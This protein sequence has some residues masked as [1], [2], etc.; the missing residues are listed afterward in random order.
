MVY[1]TG[2]GQIIA[3]LRKILASQSDLVTKIPIS[4]KFDLSCRVPTLCAHQRIFIGNWTHSKFSLVIWP[5]D[6]AR[7]I[8]EPN[9]S[10]EGASRANSAKQVTRS[11]EKRG[12]PRAE[13]DWVRCD[14]PL[15]DNIRAPGVE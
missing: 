6:L 5:G 7:I 15:V 9:F 14:A 8:H 4:D 1:S 11:P 13:G 3:H 12:S 10:K 2:I